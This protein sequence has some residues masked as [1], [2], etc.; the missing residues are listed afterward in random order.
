MKL[1]ATDS[2]GKIAPIN[3]T[4]GT[5]LFINGRDVEQSINNV[6]ALSAALIGLLT[7]PS[8]TTLACGLGTWSSRRGF[9]FFLRLCLKKSMKNYQLTM[10]H[11]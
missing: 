2:N 1:W 9:S 7:V 10:L 6:G 4:N 5:K 3:I 11:L 8:D